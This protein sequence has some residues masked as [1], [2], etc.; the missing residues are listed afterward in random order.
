MITPIT[1]E[2]I[3]KWANILKAKPTLIKDTFSIGKYNNLT[4][5]L[6]SILQI[7]HHPTVNKSWFQGFHFLFNNQLNTKLGSDGYDNYQAPV[8]EQG[9][10]LYLRRM[11]AR[12]E[13]EFVSTPSLNSPID[14]R[15]TLKSVRIIDDSVLVSIWRDFIFQSE[16]VLKESR[17]L[18][19]TN[20]LY[21]PVENY[22]LVENVSSNGPSFHVS[23][24]D[25]LKYS[26][27]TY[28]LHKI[29]IDANY[30]RS[31]ENLPNMIVHGPLQVTLLLYWFAI[32]YPD[33][34]PVNFKYRTYAPMFVN[35]DTSISIESKSNNSFVLEIYNQESKK[36]YLRGDLTTTSST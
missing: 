9:E 23:S 19:Y 8:N 16:E 4:N 3:Y 29:H 30:C 32:T 21:S 33:V 28:N 12:G 15:E 7:N 6:N 31:I 1:K 18:T 13:L 20:E 26:M 35:D 22:K 17:T 11:W 2:C 14:C 34:K 10:Q 5:L 36:L 27:L 24:I 25:L